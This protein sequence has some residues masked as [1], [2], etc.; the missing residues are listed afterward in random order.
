M[1]ILVVSPPTFGKNV[2]GAAKETF[3]NLDLLVSMG[4][5]VTLYVIGA[6]GSTHGPLIEAFA[7]EHQVT[8]RICEPDLRDWGR[9]FRRVLTRSLGYL[10]RAAYVFD[11]MIEDPEFIRYVDEW[12][13]DAALFFCS[14]A[15]PVAPFFR[16]RGIPSILR[17]HNYEP[18][19]FWES[20]DPPEWFNPLNWL[21]YGAKVIG[22]HHAVVYS[23]AVA[24]LP[25]DGME[26]YRTWKKENIFVHTI[27]YPYKGLRGPWVHQGKSPL[28]IMYLGASYLVRFHLRGAEEL[29][30]HIAPEVERRAPGRFRFHIL[31]SKM[32]ER[33][34]N[35]CDG[36]SVIYEGYVDDFEG[37]LE[38][39]DAGA[40]PVYT[41]KVIKGKVFESMARAFP[42]V[43][44]QN[45]LGGYVLKDGEEVLMAETNDAFVEAI[46][47]L[48]SDDLR[49]KLSTGA[50]E[51]AKQ[52]F[53]YEA[54]TAN[55][56]KILSAA[57]ASRKRG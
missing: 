20:L 53:S 6:P 37:F 3:G 56:S 16:Q 11:F 44:P 12:K 2:G 49:L 57:I 52:D 17:S 43:I 29:I 31:G 13:P 54:L 47:S 55:L 51:F 8:V 28:D 21:R 4:H 19:F 39:M 40:F 18:D 35:L 33:V 45:C 22:E 38:G 1:K 50:A 34:A 27:S 15:W 7:K 14:Y 10:D 26:W 41:G 9:Y 30:R 24:S 48:Q 32:P 23:D 25:F 46:L 5:E 42:I 36:K